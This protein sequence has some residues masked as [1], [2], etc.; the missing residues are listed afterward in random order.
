MFSANEVAEVPY[1]D[2]VIVLLVRV[3]VSYQGMS[4]RYG[5][6]WAKFCSDIPSAKDEFILIADNTFL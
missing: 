6:K 4:K 5:Q 2:T 3:P 1:R